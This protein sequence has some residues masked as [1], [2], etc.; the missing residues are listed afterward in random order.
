MLAALAMASTSFS[1]SFC[2]AFHSITLRLRSRKSN[3]QLSKRSSSV[4]AGCKVATIDR[5]VGICQAIVVCQH[6]Q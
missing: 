3:L 2:I 1:S 5:F 4:R 6:C